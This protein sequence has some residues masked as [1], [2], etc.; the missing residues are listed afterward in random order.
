MVAQLDHV[1]IILMTTGWRGWT[2]AHPS[3][4]SPIED[5]RGQ[6]PPRDPVLTA[7]AFKRQKWLQRQKLRL[8]A[9]ELEAYLGAAES[10]N[11]VLSRHG[12]GRPIPDNNYSS[13][14]SSGHSK[15]P[16]ESVAFYDEP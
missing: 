9:T 15:S 7:A 5:G 11:T 2:K 16:V 1:S 8:Q 4:R 13:R 12:Q 14:P 3:W 10:H 6:F